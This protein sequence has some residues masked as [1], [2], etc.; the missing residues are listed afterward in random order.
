MVLSIRNILI[1]N[2]L[3]LGIKTKHYEKTT[4]NAH[5]SEET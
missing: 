2:N 4:T 3:A 1:K 5:T